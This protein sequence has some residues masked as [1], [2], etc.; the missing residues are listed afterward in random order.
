M[1][2]LSWLL[3]IASLTAAC[4]DSSG[5]VVPPRGDAGHDAAPPREE[6]SGPPPP[7]DSGTT[8]K[9]A[10]GCPS[11]GLAWAKM[12]HQ[13][14]FLA[15]PKNM[16]DREVAGFDLDGASGMGITL[17][18]VESIL[19]PGSPLGRGPDLTQLEGWGGSN[20]VQAAYDPKTLLVE[21]VSLYPGYYGTLVLPTDP[22]GPD[23]GHTF[24][25]GLGQVL[26]DG[27]PFVIDW[28]DVKFVAG[29]EL[30]NAIAYNA[31]FYPGYYPTS[32]LV[33]G[34]CAENS[35][36]GQRQWQLLD[37]D[38]VFTFNLTGTEDE[39]SSVVEIDLQ[40]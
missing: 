22:A 26:K 5:S 21:Q 33:L 1:R 11:V 38:V 2:A 29:T 24:T 14:I 40:P 18:E 8:N 15:D 28:G 4:G 17:P 20:E 35:S 31:A 36:S 7:L 19:C 9:D 30:Y 27:A 16:G 32:C 25:V 12:D 10:G 34:A 6:D 3:S 37:L 39:Q 23:A 13:P